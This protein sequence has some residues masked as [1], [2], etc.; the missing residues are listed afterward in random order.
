M[1]VLQHYRR[2]WYRLFAT[3]FSYLEPN[4]FQTFPEALHDVHVKGK[5]HL[6]RVEVSGITPL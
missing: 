5:K 3:A 4:T 1:Q 6:S 2:D